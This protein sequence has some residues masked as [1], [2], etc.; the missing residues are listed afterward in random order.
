MILVQG[1]V[2]ILI[3]LMA[4][5]LVVFSSA[6]L[7]LHFLEK[8]K[9]LYMNH[10]RK[11]LIS[12]LP[13]TEKED[14][15]TS[16]LAAKKQPKKIASIADIRGIRSILGLQVIEETACDEKE[17]FLLFLRKEVG[18]EWYHQYF[19]RILRRRNVDSIILLIK[20]IGLLGLHQ[21]KDDITKQ[22]YRYNKNPQVQYTALLS[23]CFLGAGE[24]IISICSSTKIQFKLSF[25]AMNELFG[26]FRGDREWFYGELLSHADDQYVRRACLKCVGKEEITSLV[27]YILPYLES[28]SV[29]MKIEAINILGKMKKK[30]YGENVAELMRSDIWEV[31]A[32]VVTALGRI[33][34]KKYK[35][36]LLIGLQDKNW[37]VRYRAGEA[38]G[39]MAEDSFLMAEIGALSD[40]FAKDMMK[41]VLDKQELEKVTENDS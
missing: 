35:N 34:G 24:E 10:L 14:G 29:N 38:L 32:A 36:D 6:L 37:W 20:V 22:L 21:Y 41:F 28:E 15:E 13:D 23:L 25:R 16:C 40:P 3:V 18:G 11:Q 26:M 30:E 8:I 19:C 9:S 27:T 33:D 12:L 31:R 5:M 2:N 17:A 7:I 1:V 39:S 4:A